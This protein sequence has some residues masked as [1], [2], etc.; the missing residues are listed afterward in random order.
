MTQAEWL[1]RYLAEFERAAGLSP[2][3]ADAVATT[4]SFAEASSGYE[5]DPE[6]AAREEMS[7]WE[8]DNVKE[9]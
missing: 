4:V 3:Q 2:K 7:Y 1:N 8:P 9:S 5:S 6:G